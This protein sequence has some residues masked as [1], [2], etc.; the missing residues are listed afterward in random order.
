MGKFL[1]FLKGKVSTLLGSK[2]N[3]I[4]LLIL[5]ILILAVPLGVNLLRNR[6]IFKSKAVVDPIV[7]TGSDARKKSDGTWVITQPEVALQITSSLGPPVSQNWT[8]PPATQPPVTQPPA[9]LPSA[10]QPPATQPPATTPT[11]P[12][13]LGNS[14]VYIDPNPASSGTRVVMIATAIFGCDTYITFNPGSG[15]INCPDKFETITCGGGNP[16]DSHP[17]WWKKTCTASSPGTYIASF[18]AR[19]SNCASDLTYTIR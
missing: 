19:G 2:R 8:P 6:Q 3:L 9:T 14:N 13:P 4:N 16:K 10:T 7:L 18:N 17:C 15:L 12:P 11:P 5:G 1:D